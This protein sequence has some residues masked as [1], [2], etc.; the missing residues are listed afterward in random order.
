M[1]WRCLLYAIRGTDTQFSTFLVKTEEVCLMDIT[2]D[3]S[4]RFSDSW[5]THIRLS[6]ATHVWVLTGGTQQQDRWGPKTQLRLIFLFLEDKKRNMCR[7][8]LRN[9]Y[10]WT[11]GRNILLPSLM[12]IVAHENGQ[13]LTIR[14]D[15]LIWMSEAFSR[16]YFIRGSTVELRFLGRVGCSLR[17]RRNLSWLQLICRKVL[18][19][20]QSSAEILKMCSG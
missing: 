17:F 19:L 11:M 20:P 3:F 14:K 13:Q 6:S 8:Y 1:F 4:Y 15:I 18:S 10:C 9:I 16:H 7:F 12:S 5:Q 2:A